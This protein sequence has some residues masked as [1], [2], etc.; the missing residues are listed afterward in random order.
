MYE[1]DFEMQIPLSI[2]D[3]TFISHSHSYDEEESLK[4]CTDLEKF[5]KRI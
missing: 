5:H 3:I 1:E 2:K 4:N